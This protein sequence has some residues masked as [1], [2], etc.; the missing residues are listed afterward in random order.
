MSSDN[1]DDAQ[2]NQVTTGSFAIE[3]DTRLPPE[4]KQKVSAR[5]LN[6][7]NLQLAALQQQRQSAFGTPHDAFE[8]Y[9][10]R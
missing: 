5:E 3:A 4:K 2:L 10:F 8:K 9:G 7:T 6:K 1:G